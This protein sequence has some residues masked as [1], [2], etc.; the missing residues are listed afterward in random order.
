MNRRT[1]DDNLITFRNNLSDRDM[2]EARRKAPVEEAHQ[3]KKQTL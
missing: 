1:D 3:Y 2:Q